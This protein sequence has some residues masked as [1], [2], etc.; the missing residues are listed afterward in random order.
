MAKK[1]S[2]GFGGKGARSD[3]LHEGLAAKSLV[4]DLEERE[5]GAKC[6]MKG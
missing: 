3:V 2:S 1:F 5:P 4:Q 6:Y